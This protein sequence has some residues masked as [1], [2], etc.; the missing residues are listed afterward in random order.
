METHTTHGH[1][2]RVVSSLFGLPRLTEPKHMECKRCGLFRNSTCFLEYAFVPNNFFSTTKKRHRR[3]RKLRTCISCRQ[4][5]AWALRKKENIQRWRWFATVADV[6]DYS[7][8]ET[9]TAMSSIERTDVGHKKK[10][11]G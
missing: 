7:V 11:S 10:N 6:G 3:K 8:A 4:N 2:R 1:G 5:R 9:L